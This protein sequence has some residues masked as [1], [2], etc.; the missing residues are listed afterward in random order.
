MWAHLHLYLC[1]NVSNIRLIKVCFCAAAV[2]SKHSEVQIVHTHLNAL[3]YF[4]NEM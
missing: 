2:Q 3:L 1:S 4:T